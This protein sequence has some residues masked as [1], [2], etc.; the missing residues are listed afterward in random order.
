MGKELKQ[1]P[2]GE[3]FPRFEK[4]LEVEQP[5]LLL[6]MESSC[7]QLDGILKTGSPQDQSRAQAA[8]TAYLRT[9]ELYR[10]LAELRDQ[11]FAAA[12]NNRELSRDK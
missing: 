7:R 1:E 6:K 10:R 12:S 11:T 2:W 8:M 3:R 5:E 4:L 9:L